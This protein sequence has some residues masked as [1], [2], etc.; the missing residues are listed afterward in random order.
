MIKLRISE[1]IEDNTINDNIIATVDDVVS[2]F[3]G[4]FVAKYEI[5]GEGYVEILIYETGFED[6][7]S[8]FQYVVEYYNGKLGVAYGSNGLKKFDSLDEFE[9]FINDDLQDYYDMSF[10]YGE[11]Y[12]PGYPE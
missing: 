1:G 11:Y 5:C 12:E 10:G 7:A 4:F 8:E 6:G 9:K 2:R 3:N